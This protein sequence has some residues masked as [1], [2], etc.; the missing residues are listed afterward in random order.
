MLPGVAPRYSCESCEY[1]T[2]KTSSWLK[3]LK[4]VKHQGLS[5][6]YKCVCGNSYVYRSGLNRHKLVCT[7]LGAHKILI[8][9][10]NKPPSNFCPGEK[11]VQPA[12]HAIAANVVLNTLYNCV[13]QNMKEN[14]SDGDDADD[15]A[16]FGDDSDDIDDDSAHTSTVT[17]INLSTLPFHLFPTNGGHDGSV[18]Q[19]PD[20]NLPVSEL[21]GM[22]MTVMKENQELRNIIMEQTKQSVERE[23][24]LMELAQRPSTTTNNNIINNNQR[25]NILN[26][27]NTEC[28]DAISLTEFMDSIE[29]SMDDMYYTRDNGYV[30]GI[31]NVINREFGA[32]SQSERPIHCTDKKRLKFFVKGKI[33]W[34]KDEDH[35]Q[36][37]CVV[38]NITEKHRLLLA[39]WKEMHPNWLSEEALQN[40][41]L[42]LTSQIFNGG[43]A[44]GEKNRKAIVKNL[45]ETTE[46]VPI[47]IQSSNE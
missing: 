47:P 16:E 33:K 43:T 24:K 37:N 14:P 35:S 27:L 15:S 30:K 23:N 26:Y 18:H 46:V 4:T 34:E 29:L 19:V 10:S 22:F 42:L 12:Q 7:V 21:K 1:S 17:S 36:L 25:V 32:L 11:V 41:Y 6:Q 3:H 40:E 45:S 39:Q 38:D 5:K 20:D 9:S 13:M 28:K 44:N 31:C 2:C 8:G